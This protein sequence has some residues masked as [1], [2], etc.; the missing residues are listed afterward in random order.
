MSDMKIQGGEKT[1]QD[2]FGEKY[3]FEI[4]H[5]QRPYSWTVNEAAELLDD[6][7]A[8]LGDDDSLPIDKVPPY[9]LGCI[10]LI[11]QEHS[12]DA[13]VV[14]GQ[15]RLTT[16]TI[17]LAALRETIENTERS[18]GLTTFL[19]AKGN[20][21]LGTSDRY[22]LLVRDRDRKFFQEFVQQPGGLAKLLK[23]DPKQLASISQLNLLG[24]GVFLHERLK[25]VPEE[26]RQRLATFLLTRCV[27]VVVSSP[28]LDSAYRIFSVLNNR[29]LDL[30]HTD[31]LKAE[32]IG[33][34]P[35]H[36]SEEYSEKWEEAENDLG[37]EAFKDLFAHI[38]MVYRRQKLRETVLKEFRDFV[39]P[40][41]SPRELIDDVVLPMA[42]AYQEIKGA[43][44]ESTKHAEPINDLFRWLNQIDNFDWLP[45]AIAFLRDHHEEPEAL[46]SFFKDLERL[47]TAMMLIRTDITRRIDRYGK[48]LG[49]MAEKQDLTAPTSPLQLTPDERQAA[50]AALDGNI[51][52]VKN[53]PRYVLLRLDQLLSDAEAR[54]DHS[55][56]SIEHVLPQNPDPVSEWVKLFPSPDERDELVHRIGNLV[57]LSHRKNTSASNFDFEKKKKKYFLG[58]GKTSPF[59]LTTQ[60]LNEPEWTPDVVRRRQG[61]LLTTLKQLWRLT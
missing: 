20:P 47:A 49:A 22:R 5:Y 50:A 28:D 36:L 57:L 38:R 3:A 1:I 33:K 21:N 23:K 45:P 9:F 17:L 41:H 46:L 19:Y 43:A 52:L 53:V 29:G 26:R 35:E 24:N 8:A 25:K 14:D 48:V 16:L 34:L 59:A 30:S 2:V 31:I 60:V 58:K 61:E 18:E 42:D 6:L 15:Q 44:Y 12:T 40:K 10:V 54:Y 39:V 13:K 32:V 4:P 56:V 27:L 51:Y 7:S 37:V 11:K 55:V